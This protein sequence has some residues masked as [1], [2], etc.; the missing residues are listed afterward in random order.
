M[1][2]A[3][4]TTCS[5]IV[6][7]ALHSSTLVRA[8]QIAYDLATAVQR[9]AEDYATTPRRAGTLPTGMRD[10]RRNDSGEGLPKFR[11]LQCA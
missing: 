4:H 2:S 11:R 9:G 3:M 10:L 6:H 7:T 5:T 8:G 1:E